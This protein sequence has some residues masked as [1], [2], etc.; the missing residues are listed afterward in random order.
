[1]PKFSEN[2]PSE[3]QSLALIEDCGNPKR[4]FQLFRT[5]NLEGAGTAQR[6]RRFGSAHKANADILSAVATAR[7]RQTRKI[8]LQ[9][10]TGSAN[11]GV[12]FWRL[13]RAGSAFRD[14]GAKEP[15]LVT[16]LNQS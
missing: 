4:S 9:L 3:R 1:M 16:L 6:L 13:T 5:E 11:I 10:L 2:P 7:C 8:G 15:T 12:R 14:S